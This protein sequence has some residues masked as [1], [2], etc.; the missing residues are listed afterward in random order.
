MDVAAV[1]TVYYSDCTLASTPKPDGALIRYKW[2]LKED[3][4]TWRTLW[5]P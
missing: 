1:I 4:W 3:E 2:R 5:Q